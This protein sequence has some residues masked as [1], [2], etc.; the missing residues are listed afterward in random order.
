[1]Q[2]IHRRKILTVSILVGIGVCPLGRTTWADEL[3][4]IRSG[5]SSARA[6]EANAPGQDDR[7]KSGRGDSLHPASLDDLLADGNGG[8]SRG[9]D[10]CTTPDD[11]PPL[12]QII[13]DACGINVCEDGMCE[14]G[15]AC[16]P[17]ENCDGAGSCY[18]IVFLDANL[19]YLAGPENEPFNTPFT[20]SDFETARI[21]QAPQLTIYFDDGSCNGNILEDPAAGGVT[22]AVFALGIP[23]NSALYAIDFEVAGPTIENASIDLFIRPND[24]LGGGPNQGVYINGIPLSGDT[25][26]GSCVFDSPLMNIYRTD[27][28]PL[29]HAGT[30]TLYLN[31]TH[32]G[33]DSGLLFTAEIRV[34]T[35]GP[36]QVR[37]DD[38]A[39]PGGDGTSWATAFN[40][41]QDAIDDLEASDRPKPR[42]LV[43]R[44]RL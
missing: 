27:I 15:S 3:I 4:V 16:S 8:A 26:G 24:T 35:D 30:N 21:G 29:L 7:F 12:D 20:P 44:R 38:D 18:Q 33:G 5:E 1:M 14:P 25:T 43:G 22:T 32:T 23:S 42:G 9:D 31:V 11:C 36:H 19:T 40:S 17:L 2:Q 13:I 41:L 28:G 10:P 37:V 6:L 34:D 39:P